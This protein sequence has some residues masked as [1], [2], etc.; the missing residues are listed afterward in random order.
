VTRVVPE[1]RLVLRYDTGRFECDTYET[2][3]TTSKA[4]DAM[5]DARMVHIFVMKETMI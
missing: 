3:G 1:V 2:T 5:H 4:T